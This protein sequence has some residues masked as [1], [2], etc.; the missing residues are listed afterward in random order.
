MAPLPLLPGQIFITCRCVRHKT[1]THT[2]RR[3]WDSLLE[4]PRRM[5]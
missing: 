3:L 2:R 1:L 4:T 5:D